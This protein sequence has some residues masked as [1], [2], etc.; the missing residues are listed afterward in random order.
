VPLGPDPETGY[1]EFA[2]LATG[3]RIPVRGDD[4]RIAIGDDAG[5]V[6]TLLPAQTVV[7]D[8]DGREVD[9][10][11]FFIAK[12]E[13]SVGQLVYLADLLPLRPDRTPYW[14]IESP[15]TRARPAADITWRTAKEMMNHIGLDLPTGLQWRYACAAAPGNEWWTGSDPESVRPV[16]NFVDFTKPRPDAMGTWP[17]DFAPAANRHGL[18]N[19]HGNVAEWLVDYSIRP[20]GDGTAAV[21][22]SPAVDGSGRR[23]TQRRHRHVAGG[24]F[25]DDPADNRVP[26]G[27]LRF[28][29]LDGIFRGR[30]LGL[31]PVRCLDP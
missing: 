21:D 6:L 17:V 5:M 31:R 8:A 23:N 26:T 12:F 10:Q 28:D 22:S 25:N 11:P 16:A 4:G 1:Q 24:G 19:M 14:W 27:C 29:L 3:K 7:N 2:V 15:T 20:T 9:L 18:F 13:L 30:M